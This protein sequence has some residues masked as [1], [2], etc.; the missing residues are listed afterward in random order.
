MGI[1]DQLNE[2]GVGLKNKTWA[3]QNVCFNQECSKENFLH[4]K[5]LQDARWKITKHCSYCN[6]ILI[7]LMAIDALYQTVM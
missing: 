6:I 3:L 7:A 5:N 4:V 1:V 2:M